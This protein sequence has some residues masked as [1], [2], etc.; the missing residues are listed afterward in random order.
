MISET[1][2]EDGRYR[3]SNAGGKKKRYQVKIEVHKARHEKE[4]WAKQGWGECLVILRKAIRSQSCCLKKCREE[5]LE[6]RE[7][8][9]CTQS[10]ASPAGHEVTA[11]EPAGQ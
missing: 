1:M 11:E 10:M 6:E 7:R 8:A 4:V 2:R 9:R 5:E 3:E